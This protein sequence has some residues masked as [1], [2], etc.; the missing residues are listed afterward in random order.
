M[1]IELK[2]DIASTF[3]LTA[4]QNPYP[5]IK[6]ILL[7]LLTSEENQSKANNIEVLLTTEPEFL[8]SEEWLIDELQLQQ[9]TKLQERPLKPR[10][11]I[12]TSLTE[13]IKV[14]FLFKISFSNQNGETVEQSTIYSVNVLP[15]NY[16]GGESRQSE[17]LAAFVQPN[18]HT[19][20]LLTSRVTQ[21]LRSSG[22][23]SAIDGYQSNTRDRPYL[24]GS[25]LWSTIFNER[26]AYLSPPNG[27]ATTGQRI[28]SAA[29][30]LKY[31]T[32]ACLDTSIL[33]ASCFENMGLNPIIAIT[34]D[35]AFAGFWLIDDAFPHLTHDDAM[36][37]RK[38]IS[39]SN[40]VMFETT[41][42]TNDSKVT[43]KQAIDRASELLSEEN[44]DDFVMLIDIKQAR[45]RGIKPLGEIENITDDE[46]K[47]ESDGIELDLGTVPPLPKVRADD[48]IF[49][50]SQS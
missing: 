1:K 11:D 5:L 17:L 49:V 36:D 30:I 20:D 23:G 16:W 24:F 10:F 42:V 6:N 7:S 18:V 4:Q 35:H 38:K 25:A 22:E 27:W 45:T 28:R 33:F 43:F 47:H 40:I 14:D 32:A 8:E 39:T 19:V 31:K 46:I 9:S 3:S 34:K 48:R 2:L 44:E 26:V 41:L 12:L 50:D 21:L 15:S 29:D 37:L 13:E